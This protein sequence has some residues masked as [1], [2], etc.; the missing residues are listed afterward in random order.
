[1]TEETEYPDNT[2][3][4]S[5]VT[6]SADVTMLVESPAAPPHHHNTHHFSGS[7]T[8]DHILTAEDPATPA[9]AAV[10]AAAQPPPSP[11]RTP[12]LNIQRHKD[13]SP[14]DVTYSRFVN[15][16]ILSVP[17]YIETAAAAARL[18]K[19]AASASDPS[20]APVT[21]MGGSP[22][23][24]LVASVYGFVKYFLR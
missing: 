23:D 14:P 7:D 20:A 10:V 13:A 15:G 8:R 18:P 1:M 17:E 16:S 4:T 22:G 11:P 9:P 12:S 3:R 5:R 21:K 24:S 6:A 2:R 19:V